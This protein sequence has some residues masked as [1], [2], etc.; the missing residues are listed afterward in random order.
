MPTLAELN[1]TRIIPSSYG[2]E[3]DLMY[4]NKKHKFNIFGQLYR[5][6]APCLLESKTAKC[7]KAAVKLAKERYGWKLII[8]DAFRPSEA[9]IKMFDMQGDDFSIVAP[10]GKSYHTR[11]AAIDVSVKGVDMGAKVDEPGPTGRHDCFELAKNEQKNKE[12]LHNR[13]RLRTLM[14]DAGLEGINNE[15]WHYQLPGGLVGKPI[16]DDQLP[17]K[18]KI[19]V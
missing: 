13:Y 12:F 16:K 1:L 9:Q 4:A 10:P 3:V 15:W 19:L 5:A 7:L 2:V 17:D 14:L 18:Y 6:D 11:G 8:H